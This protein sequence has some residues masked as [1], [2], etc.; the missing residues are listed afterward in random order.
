MFDCRL[1]RAAVWSLRVLNVSLPNLQ[2]ND[3]HFLEEPSSG[4]MP[5]VPILGTPPSSIPR[6]A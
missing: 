4:A 2:R 3:L 1:P 6:D 5:R